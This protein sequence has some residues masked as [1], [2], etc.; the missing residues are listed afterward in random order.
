MNLLKNINLGQQKNIQNN[1]H[2][3]KM[4]TGQEQNPSKHFMLNNWARVDIDNENDA[5]AEGSGPSKKQ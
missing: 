5:E 3:K 2:V 4:P 1:I